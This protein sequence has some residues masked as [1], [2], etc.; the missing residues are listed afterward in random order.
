[1]EATKQVIRSLAE[2]YNKEEYFGGDPVIFPKHFARIM[3]GETGIG[4]LGGN[5]ELSG[6]KYTLQDVEIAAVIAAHLAWG[7]R[8][9]IV[10]DCKRAFDE[11]GWEPY[12]YVMAGSYRNEDS[13]LHRTIKW[14]EFAAICGRLKEFYS[15]SSSLEPLTPDEIRVRV[16]GQKSDPKAAN[17]KIHMMRRW[18]VRNDGI[19]DLGLWKNTSPATLVIPLD[20]H[21]HRSSR[22]LGITSRNSADITTA[23]EITRFLSEIF[24]GDPCM[25]DFALFAYA[26]SLKG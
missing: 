26:A 20:V 5:K 11:M 9:M 18:M 10:R 1:M 12:R 2:Q 22:N 3:L 13:S 25:G 4:G 19:V 17:K 6:R 24:P 16:Y 14:S 23:M 15:T 7:R 21:V 8:D